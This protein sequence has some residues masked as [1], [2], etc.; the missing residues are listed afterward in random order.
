MTIRESILHYQDKQE[1]SDI[2]ICKSCNINKSTYSLFRNEKRNLPPEK[3]QSV[4]DF[5]NL[6]IT[7]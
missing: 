5:L 2:A 7:D 4:L 6:K 1:I 3:L